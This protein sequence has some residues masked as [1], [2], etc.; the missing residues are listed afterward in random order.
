MG[1]KIKETRIKAGL[2]Q[3]R[4]SFRARMA[5]KGKKTRKS[6]RKNGK[7]VTEMG[8]W[9]VRNDD[10]IELVKKNVSPTRRGRQ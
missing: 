6:W 4:S 9:S 8:A 2:V 10:E 3:N 5:K 7:H 1:N